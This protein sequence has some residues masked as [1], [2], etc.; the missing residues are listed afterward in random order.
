MID[1]VAMGRNFAAERNKLGLT[2]TQLAEALGT[3]T[4][5]ICQ[6]ENGVY[7]LPPELANAMADLCG[8]ST[9]YLYARTEERLSARN[10][11]ARS[12]PAGAEA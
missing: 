2:Q 8:C 4:K 3:N 7:A 9:D 10:A 5:S 12:A 6:Y 11:F 1:R